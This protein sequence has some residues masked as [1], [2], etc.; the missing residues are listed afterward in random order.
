MHGLLTLVHGNET[1]QETIQHLPCMDQLNTTPTYWKFTYF[2]N[3]GTDTHLLD[4]YTAF[5]GVA[6]P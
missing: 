1:P 4:L 5:S 6:S 2:V 3:F